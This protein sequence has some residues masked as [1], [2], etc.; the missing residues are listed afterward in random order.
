MPEK[1]TN[2]AN[3]SAECGAKNAV[4]ESAEICKPA[5]ASK[6]GEEDTRQA[7]PPGGGNFGITCCICILL[8][9]LALLAAAVFVFERVYSGTKDVATAVAQ[10]P[11][12]A[13]GVLREILAKAP[14][15]DV[16]YASEYI[17]AKR[18]NKFVVATVDRRESM[19]A[20]FSKWRIKNMKILT[21][22]VRLEVVAHYQYFVAFRGIKYAISKG[23]NGKIDF[24]FIFDSLKPDLPVKYTE[25]ER[26]ISQSAL[27]NDVNAE[28]EKYQKEKFPAELAKF[29]ASAQNMLCARTEAEKSM[30]KYL[31]ENILPLWNIGANE[32]GKFEIVFDTGRFE[33]FKT[34][35]TRR[36]DA[37]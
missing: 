23:E 19:G 35:I 18:E 3:N 10:T 6:N 5:D 22:S 9:F 34:G 11:S 16:V 17:A 12:K 13:V 30:E 4:S 1:N 21:G 7:Q 8:A 14:D 29:A 24:V 2:R 20:D 31:R 27:S 33:N 25:I 36:R 26:N 37:K 32:I 28:L 15:G